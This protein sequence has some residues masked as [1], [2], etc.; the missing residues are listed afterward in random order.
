MSEN[1]SELMITVISNVLFISLFIGFFFFT[2]AVN[3]EK[4]IVESQMKYLSEEIISKVKIFGIDAVSMFHTYISN[5]PKPVLDDVD[6]IVEKEN[7]SIKYKAL[8]ANIAFTLV[9]VGLIYLIYNNSDK[10][11]EIKDIL[12]K[13]GIILFFIALTE[14][15]FLDFFGSKYVSLNPN[16][17]KYSII[18]N[19]KDLV[20][21]Q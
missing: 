7:S 13:N 15:L 21:K 16:I 8:Y 19:I 5:V 4:A 1:Y 6:K 18:E 11:F 14:Y 10:S 2:Y 17:V 9:V 3:I 20:F 12:I